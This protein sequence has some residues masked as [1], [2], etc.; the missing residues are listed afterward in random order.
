MNSMHAGARSAAAAAAAAARLSRAGAAPQAAAAR[1]LTTARMGGPVPAAAAPQSV[2]SLQQTAALRRLV[3]AGAP[4]RSSV[5]ASE[6]HDDFKP[7]PSADAEQDGDIQAR[8]KEVG[9][10]GRRWCGMH[11]GMLARGCWL[12]CGTGAVVRERFA[13]GGLLSC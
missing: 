12:S 9:E 3:G 13:A 10:S 2:A 7:V 11:C 5:A 4:R 6:T 8:I 1:R